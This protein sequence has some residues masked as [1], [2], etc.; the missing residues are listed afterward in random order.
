MTRRQPYVL[1]FAAEVTKHLKFI[2]A[3]YHAL[4]REQ[5]SDQLRFEPGIAT[6]NR[7][8]LRLPALFGATWELRFGPGN[9]F[10]VLYNVDDEAR[11]VLILAVG[12]KRRE[13]LMIAGEVVCL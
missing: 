5:I 3:K 4:V 10:R 6:T 11:F 2:D 9:R 7:K 13:R 8:P 1:G 12:E